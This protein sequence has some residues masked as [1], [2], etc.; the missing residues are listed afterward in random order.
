[1]RISNL[2]SVDNI[3]IP[4]IEI[5]LLIASV[6]NKS[7]SFLY[8]HPEYKLTIKQ[9]RKF[10]S[11]FNRLSMGEPLAYILGKKSFWT[12]ELTVDKRVLIPRP[13]TEI[14]VEVVLSKLIDKPFA[15]IADLGTGS[16]AIAIALATEH[17]T[18][19]VFAADISKDALQLACYNADQLQVNN[20]KFCCG[21]WCRA[22]PQQ[23]FDA[24]VSNPPYVAKDDIHLQQKNIMFEPKIALEA[25]DGLESLDT[26]IVQARQFLKPQGLL[27]LEYGYDQSKKVKYLLQKSNYK[28]IKLYKDLSGITRAV[29]ASSI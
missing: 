2:L 26:I 5:E 28:N 1:M 21:N 18:W 29:S 25:V 8:S 23:K 3:F 17:P 19:N 15:T 22:L 9:K 12:F 10:Y 24:I 27:V 20:I 14:L 6:L 13:E 11:L 4:K 7:R 16:G